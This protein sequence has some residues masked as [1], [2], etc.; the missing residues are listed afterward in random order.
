MGGHD[1]GRTLAMLWEKVIDW[2]S[3]L[4]SA[5]VVDDGV[6]KKMDRP[7]KKPPTSSVW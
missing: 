4:G 1:M 6:E 5:H 3:V 7:R 2:L